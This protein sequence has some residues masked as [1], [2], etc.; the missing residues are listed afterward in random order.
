MREIER[1]ESDRAVSW[2]LKAD[3]DDDGNDDD[4]GAINPGD[5]FEKSSIF[6]HSKPQL[7][8]IFSK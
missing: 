7:S 5:Q 4:S 1:G 8:N 3:G 2:L 6:Y